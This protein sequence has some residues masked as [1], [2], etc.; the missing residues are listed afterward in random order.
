[1]S[2]APAASLTAA[3]L[4]SKGNAHLSRG[5][6]QPIRERVSVSAR[7]AGLLQPE[8]EHISRHTFTPQT[9][10]IRAR[11][12][13][14]SLSLRIDQKQSLRLRLA[15]AHLGKSRQVIL[16][17]ALD[18]YFKKIL[19]DVLSHPCP[20]IENGIASGDD[21]CGRAPA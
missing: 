7:D 5:L 21:C 12:A 3:L 20:C 6:A 15:S 11:P 2:A 4:V 10:P 1:M 14:V 16:L 19:P 17:E 13:P 8:T 18:H 9:V